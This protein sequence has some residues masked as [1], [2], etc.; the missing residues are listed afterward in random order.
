MQTSS[1]SLS[2][3]SVLL[4]SELSCTTATDYSPCLQL[5]IMQDN[6]ERNKDNKDDWW[7]KKGTMLQLVILTKMKPRKANCH[8]DDIGNGQPPRQQ[9]QDQKEDQVEN[10]YKSNRTVNKA[11]TREAGD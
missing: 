10:D 7:K 8:D 11:V 3:K 2:A 6:E 1:I 9:E 5:I 4:P